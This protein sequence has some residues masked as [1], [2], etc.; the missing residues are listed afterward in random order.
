MGKAQQ[1]MGILE[2]LSSGADRRN[3]DFQ[4]LSRLDPSNRQFKSLLQLSKQVSSP[5]CDIGLI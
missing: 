3:T 4:A 5:R 1:G 2:P